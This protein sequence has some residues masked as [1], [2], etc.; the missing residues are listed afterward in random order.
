M[1]TDTNEGLELYLEY[2]KL[3]SDYRK[4]SGQPISFDGFRTMTEIAVR[5]EDIRLKLQ[6]RQ[7]AT[8]AAP[9]A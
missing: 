9:T 5:L 8:V 7:P 6:S 2:A 4:L 1:W 3:I